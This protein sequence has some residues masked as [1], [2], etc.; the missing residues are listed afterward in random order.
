VPTLPQ[1]FA[2]PYIGESMFIIGG[3]F[4]KNRGHERRR[5]ITE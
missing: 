4:E 1:T 5:D 2:R 3:L